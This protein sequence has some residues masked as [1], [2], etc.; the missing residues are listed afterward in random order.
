MAPTSSVRPAPR[1]QIIG[2]IGVEKSAAHGSPS[3]LLKQAGADCGFSQPAKPGVSPC[4][5]WPIPSI[6]FVGLQIARHLRFCGAEGCAQLP[7]S[8]RMIKKQERLLLRNEYL[9]AENRI[10]KAQIPGGCVCQTRI[11]RRLARLAIDWAVEPSARWR[12]QPCRTPFWGGID[13]LSPASSMVANHVEALADPVSIGGSSSSLCAW[14]KRIPLGAMI[15][16]SGR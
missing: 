5:R 11:G 10:L 4:R 7:A 12:M 6:I 16:S 1:L 15:A 14:P 8:S 9:V 3:L 2:G 13:G